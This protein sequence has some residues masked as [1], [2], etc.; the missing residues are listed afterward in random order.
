[1]LILAS[2]KTASEISGL[3]SELGFGHCPAIV[4][5]GSGLL[6][7]GA[8]TDTD[9]RPYKR[10]RQVLD[11]VPLNLRQ[12]FRGFGDLTAAEVAAATGLSLERAVLA[13]QRA[14]SEPGQWTGSTKAK[15]AFLEHLAQHKIIAQQGG[16]FLTLSHGSNKADQVRALIAKH[17]PEHTIALGDATNDRDILEAT[18]FGVII[19]NPH[20]Q[21][22]GK[23]AGEDQGRILRTQEPGPRG[24]NAAMLKLLEDLG[25]PAPEM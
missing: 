24:W 21:T 10:I 13:K 19:A 2:S 23:L 25:F 6:C 11:T 9:D 14:F 7:P 20:G 5:N 17:T 16:R 4:E 22:L 12:C 18:E 3:R 1:M 15:A 8:A